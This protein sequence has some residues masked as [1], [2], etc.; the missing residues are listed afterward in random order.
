MLENRIATKEFKEALESGMIEKAFTINGI[1]FYR[2]AKDGMDIPMARWSIM[3][4]TAKAYNDYGMSIPVAVDYV[5][6]SYECF[7]EILK[8]G[9]LDEIR[10]L[11]MRGYISSKTHKDH[12]ENI[13]EIGLLLEVS[14]MAFLVEGENPYIVDYVLNTHKIDL[15]QSTMASEGGEDFL[16]FFSDFV[17]RKCLDWI[18]PLMLYIQSSQVPEEMMTEQMMTIKKGR[19]S[20]LAYQVGQSLSHLKELRAGTNLKSHVPALRTLLNL[21]KMRLNDLASS[22]TSATKE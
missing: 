15:W 8:S 9:D 10:E 7:D 18:Q 14:A 4:T 11:A 20:R 17:T 6:E 19:E 22:I 3:M 13:N 2:F 12:V 16:A 1:D 5:T 21:A